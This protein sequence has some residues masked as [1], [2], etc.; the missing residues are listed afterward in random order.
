VVNLRADHHHEEDGLKIS[1]PAATVHC[2][3]LSLTGER[4]G[5]VEENRRLQKLTWLISVEEE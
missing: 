5:Q 2:Q 4:Q 1:L 3:R